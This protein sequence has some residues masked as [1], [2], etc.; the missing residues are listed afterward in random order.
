[1]IG[2]IAEKFSQATNCTNTNNQT[3]VYE[4]MHKKCKISSAKTEKLDL[5][6]NK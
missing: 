5:V 4:Q 3:Q 2:H 1:M 6:N